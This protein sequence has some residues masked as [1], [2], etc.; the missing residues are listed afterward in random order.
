MT[1]SFSVGGFIVTLAVLPVL[2]FDFVSASN[3]FGRYAFEIP[4]AIVTVFVALCNVTVIETVPEFCVWPKNSYKLIVAFCTAALFVKFALRVKVIVLPPPS[5]PVTHV[6]AQVPPVAIITITK[7]GA[8]A[9]V[10]NSVRE[11]PDVVSMLLPSKAGLNVTPK[12]ITK[13]DEGRL[14]AVLN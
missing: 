11:M 13:L 8:C 6:E 1:I 12:S 3:G 10:N 7:S 9:V 4:K 14:V 2:E 5:V